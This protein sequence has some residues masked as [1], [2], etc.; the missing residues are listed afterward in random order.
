MV[1]LRIG[2]DH[3]Y[4]VVVSGCGYFYGLYLRIPGRLAQVLARRRPGQQLTGFKEA[5]PHKVRTRRCSYCAHPVNIQHHLFGFLYHRRGMCHR[6][7]I[8]PWGA[9]PLGPAPSWQTPGCYC[10]DRFDQLGIEAIAA[11]LSL[12]APVKGD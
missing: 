1:L 4:V 3:C 11:V 8:C 2:Y 5:A 6:H 9:T 12:A 10:L 7:G